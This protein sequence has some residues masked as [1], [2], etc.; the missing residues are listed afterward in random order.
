MDKYFAVH[1]TMQKCRFKFTVK[2]L[3]LEQQSNVKFVTVIPLYCVHF[4]VVSHI[5]SVCMHLRFNSAF[6]LPDL[7]LHNNKHK[8]GDA[9]NPQGAGS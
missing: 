2:T 9:Q 6:L 4:L 3:H 5:F 8:V 1:I 7:K